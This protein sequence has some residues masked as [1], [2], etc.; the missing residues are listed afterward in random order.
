MTDAADDTFAGL[1][2]YEPVYQM[3]VAAGALELGFGT[4]QDDERVSLSRVDSMLL[5]CEESEHVVDRIWPASSLAFEEPD[6]IPSVFGAPS[7]SLLSDI[8][9][10][11]EE[12]QQVI[13]RHHP[14]GAAARPRVH[15][16]VTS[17]QVKV[18]HGL[19]VKPL[20]RLQQ[21]PD[22]R[23][24]DGSTCSKSARRNYLQRQD[25]EQVP[26]PRKSDG[27]TC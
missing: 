19:P 10:Q 15:P 21:V 7:Q 13:V 17:V 26:D 18:T 2:E 11:P 24:S 25:E 22:P 12:P 8:W 14:I 27:S 20:A 5:D 1:T 9:A 3:D 16:R 23:K 4:S 6:A